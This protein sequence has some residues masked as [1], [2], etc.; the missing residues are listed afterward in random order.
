MQQ[1]PTGIIDGA[2]NSH[3]MQ[4]LVQ[5]VQ[6]RFPEQR[7]WV[8]MGLLSTKSAAG[9]LQALGPIAHHIVAS[10]PN[11]YGKPPLPADDLAKAI[12]VHLPD[13]PATTIESVADAVAFAID[14]ATG[15]DV[16]LVTG[17]IYL[18]GEARER[19][20]PSRDQLIALET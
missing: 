18:I 5:T 16:V 9:V 4:N 13:T 20:Y 19:W 14:S 15:D 2:H 10:Q 1:A 3:K 12:G 7:V 17:S 8:V 11:V 6:K